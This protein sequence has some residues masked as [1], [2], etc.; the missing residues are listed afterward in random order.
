MDV[1]SFIEHVEE[2][3]RSLRVARCIAPTAYNVLET[4]EKISEILSDARA[5][6]A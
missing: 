5:F 1:C 4:C 2:I 6:W 3:P